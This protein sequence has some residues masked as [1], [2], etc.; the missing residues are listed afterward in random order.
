MAPAPYPRGATA[1]GQPVS[2][3]SPAAVSPASTRPTAPRVVEPTTAAT[4]PY[5]ATSDWMTCEGEPSVT[6]VESWRSRGSRAAA[7]ASFSARSRCTV[8]WYSAIGIGPGRSGR[9]ACTS[10]SGL[11]SS[12]DRVWA[13]ASGAA[14]SS[15]SASPTMIGEDMAAPWRR[16]IGHCDGAARARTAHP[17]ATALASVVATDGRARGCRAPRAT[18][19][20]SPRRRTGAPRRRARRRRRGR[21]APVHSR[22]RGHPR[23]PA[24]A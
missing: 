15:R 14:S 9:I 2:C 18:P 13:R 20:A 4:A 21:G 7:S 11:A 22:P 16:M 19:L 5:S 23:R 1:T 24:G 12:P 8:A 3:S 17:C 6:R 10:T